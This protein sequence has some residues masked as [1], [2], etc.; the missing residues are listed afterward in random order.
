MNYGK[1]GLARYTRHGLIDVSVLE[2]S[3]TTGISA[4]VIIAAIRIRQLAIMNVYK[5]PNI[6]WPKPA[7]PSFLHPAMY[8]GDLNSHHSQQDYSRN[9]AASEKLTDWA[10]FLTPNNQRV[11]AWPDGTRNTIQTCVF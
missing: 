3:T 10:S 7:L 1:Y 11:F 6:E 2:E 4:I 5:P 8:L 9:D